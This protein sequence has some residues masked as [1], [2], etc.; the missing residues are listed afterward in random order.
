METGPQNSDVEG[1]RATFGWNRRIH[2]VRQTETS[3]CGLACLTMIL[4]YF[5]NLVDLAQLRELFGSSSRG[6]SLAQLISIAQAIGVEA[7]PLRIELNEIRKVAMPYMAHFDLNHYVVVASISK[8]AIEILDPAYGRRK[9]THKEFS[10]RFTGVVLELTP[11]KDFAAQPRRK[12]LSIRKL[13]FSPRGVK[14]TLVNV[15]IISTLLELIALAMPLA[16]QTVIDRVIVESDTDLLGVVAIAFAALIILQVVAMSARSWSSAILSAN[17]DV[18]WSGRLF[19]HLLR[20]PEAYFQKRQLGDVIS[21]FGSLNTIQQTVASKSVEIALDGVMAILSLGMLFFY[22]RYLALASILTLL[23]SLSVRIV[24]YGMMQ[25]TN[26]SL[27]SLSARQQ[28]TFLESLRGVTEIKL[29]NAVPLMSSRYLNNVVATNNATISLQSLQIVFGALDSLLFGALKLA[30]LYTG[31]RLALSGHFTAGML[32]AFMSYSDQFIGRMVALFDFGLRLKILR[33]HSDR[34]SDIALS[35]EEPHA[36]SSRPFDV[37]DMTLEFEAVSFR[38]SDAEP[39]ILRNCSLS[40]RASE[41][42]A[43]FG[44][45]GCGKSTLLKLAC[46]LLEPTAGTIRI[47]GIDARIL[48]KRKQ[49]ELISVVLQENVLFAGSIAENISFFDSAQDTSRIDEVSRRAG[50][51]DDIATMPMRFQTS[52]GDMG[53]SLSGGQRQRICLA[54]ALYRD[55]KIL[56]LDEATSHLDVSRERKISENVKSMNITRIIV[57]HRPETI[58]SADRQFELQNGS[59]REVKCVMEHSESS[60]SEQPEAV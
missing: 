40:V 54:R 58:L 44:E 29:L 8:R 43:I 49:R 50:I 6:T 56:L 25:E 33:I 30:I 35:Q 41:S 24:S 46:G 28:S 45:S 32:V 23:I 10:D 26:I 19:T 37:V 47:G 53:M 52:V 18:A 39:W 16:T 2:C 11:N 9:L 59:L 13:V 36:E 48:G 42:I 57:S 5:G 14:S 21:R 17:L 20:L 7:R 1:F 51:S 55:P 15:L 60:K 34:L 12:L 31:A 22:N 27:I 4:N 3:E 38:Y